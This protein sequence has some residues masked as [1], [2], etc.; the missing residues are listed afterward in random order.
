MSTNLLLPL[1]GAVW[2]ALLV[3]GSAAAAPLAHEMYI[4]ARLSKSFM[5]GGK[6]EQA[7]GLF[8]TGDRVN[9]E[10]VGFNNPKQ[11]GIVA[12]P[13]DPNILFTVALNGVQRSL[14]GGRTWR[15]MTSWDMTEPK[16]IAIDPHAPDHLYIGLPDGV[17]VSRDRGQTW[18]RM[19]D[20]IKRSYTQLV[21]VD[22][23][24][25]GRV[26]AGTELG[27]YI[28][29]DAAKTWHR[30]FAT[31]QT[32]TD[33]KQSPHDPRVFLAVT[34]QDGAFRSADG[35]A[36]WQPVTGLPSGHTLYNCDFDA[37]DARRWVVCGWEIGVQ[38]S[39][40]GGVTWSPRNTGLPNTQMWRVAFDPDLPGRL[41]SAP[42]LESVY[43]SDDLGRTWRR[44][45]L[46]GGLIWNFTFLP[47]RNPVASHP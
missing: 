27:L 47:R 23:T 28:S 34:Q 12:D 30:A 15:I 20:G 33:I 21:I 16:S 35:G 3:A 19:N 8:R 25:A 18:T 11:D 26:F 9:I 38:L 5:I 45:W 17:G 31:E 41:Y 44:G 1:R 13:R 4:G 46:D 6:T 10:R 7:S 32:V 42:H 29:D 2:A 22:R 43:L 14:D 37:H 24:K 36:T 39:E 40:D